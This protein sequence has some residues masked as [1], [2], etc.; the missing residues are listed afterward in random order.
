MN[1]SQSTP[2]NVTGSNT[3]VYITGATIVLLGLLYFLFPEIRVLFNDGWNA[4]LSGDKEQI[5]IWVNS[6]GWLGPSMLILA[7]VAQMFLL[8]IPSI[9]LIVV[10]ILAYGPFYGSI[11][12]FAG[13]YAAS[14]V[15]YILGEFLGPVVIKKNFGQKPIEKGSYLISRYGFWIIF[16]TRLSPFL[17][18]DALSL[19]SGILKMNYWKFISANLAGIAPIILITAFLDGSTEG[20]LT[21]LVCITLI[22]LTFFAVY[23]LYDQKQNNFLFNKWRVYFID[24]VKFLNRS[25]NLN[26]RK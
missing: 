5:I 1:N 9:A 11:I 18:N 4:L 14:S 22:S 24:L 23:V 6:Y 25:F 21:G 17:Y 7:M 8:L 16:I 10:S 2:E 12:A 15:G 20:L 3:Q 26:F 19:I 13:I